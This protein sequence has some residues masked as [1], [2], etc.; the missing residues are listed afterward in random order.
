MVGMARAGDGNSGKRKR[1]RAPSGGRTDEDEPGRSWHENA[2]SWPD[3]DFAVRHVTGSA[4]TKTYRCPGCD[5][6]IRGATPHVV[7]WPES[8]LDDRRHWHSACWANR[9]TRT[10]VVLRSRNAPRL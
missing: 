4:G 3:G 2:E 10:P 7:A 8:R 6:E 5:Q 1:G 9:L